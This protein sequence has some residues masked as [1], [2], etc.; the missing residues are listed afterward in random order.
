MD[1][2][3]QVRNVHALF[4]CHDKFSDGLAGA[5]ID[6]GC[7][8]QASICLRDHLNEAVAVVFT[9]GAVGAAHLPAADLYVLPELHPCLFLGKPDVSHLGIR[10]GH[11]GNEV[12]KPGIAAW[13]QGVTRGLECL[14]PRKMSELIAAR[15]IARRVDV[16]HIG[17]QLIVNRN[18][19]FGIVDASFFE[20]EARDRWLPAGR[21]QQ[22]IAAGFLVIGRHDDLIAILAGG[23][24]P[25]PDKSDPFALEDALHHFADFRF[26][27]RQQAIGEYTNL[28]AEP[29]V[30][31]GHLHA[32]RPST[33]HDH[34][35]WQPV[36]IE[37][38][39]VRHERYFVQ[40]GNWRDPWTGARREQKRF[41]AHEL[42]A[43]HDGSPVDESPGALNH[44]DPLL[45]QFRRALELIDLLNRLPNVRANLRHLH[46]G[47]IRR[48]AESG[49][50]THFMR[51]LRRFEERFARHAAGPGAISTDPVLLNQRHL[52]PELRGKTGS[53]QTAGAGPYDHQIKI[54]RRHGRPP[55]DADGPA[56]TS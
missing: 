24:G 40:A 5:A 15:D 55:P 19:A 28:R 2:P 23:F 47:R 30:G 21:D 9:D 42:F 50:R 7:P 12:R 48:D 49:C 29:L 22:E 8:K 53:H 35:A 46:D 13:E 33:D 1:G 36:V 20:I 32:N 39:L 27:F 18:A 3:G 25:A 31:L 56:G 14:P 41:R 10:E 37:E 6:D 52:R 17:T 38:L 4:E 11:P 45:S 34:G 43:H 54:M 16:F 44:F 26:L 51:N